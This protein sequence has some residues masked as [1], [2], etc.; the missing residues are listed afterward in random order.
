MYPHRKNEPFFSELVS[1]AVNKELSLSIERII[2]D[3]IDAFLIV[4]LNIVD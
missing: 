3:R 1:L 2:Q 4:R